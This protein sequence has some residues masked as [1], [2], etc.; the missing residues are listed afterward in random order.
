MMNFSDD[1]LD[2]EV[3]MARLA[4]HSLADEQ[5]P[6]LRTDL[7][8]LMARG[9]RRLLAQ[10]LAAGVGVVVVL[11]GVALGVGLLAHHPGPASN[12]ITAA[13]DAPSATTMVAPTS[14]PGALLPGWTAVPA[15]PSMAP[16]ATSTSPAPTT[17][18]TPQT[19]ARPGS[20]VRSLPALSTAL[21]TALPTA[22]SDALTSQHLPARATSAPSADLAVFKV[23]AG[24]LLAKRQ[25]IAA[26]PA[27]NAD[28]DVGAHPG[29]TVQ[30]ETL[31]DGAVLQL[32]TLSAQEQVLN[33]YCATGVE[34]IL[35][36]TSAG[37][38]ALTEAQLAA[39]GEHLAVLR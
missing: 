25:V 8:D 10:R 6:P 28:G 39:V 18:M 32:Y 4:L 14:T 5:A 1:E 23:G 13:T 11:G 30:R 21:S 9:R 29:A 3:R 19:T 22:V 34:Y 12:G 26:G 37:A 20:G 16:R 27:E 36:L 33:V 24:D 17:T 7:D 31:P 2:G 38:P 35:Q 15:T